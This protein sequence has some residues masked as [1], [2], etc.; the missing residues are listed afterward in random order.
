MAYDP[1]KPHPPAAMAYDASKP[2]PPAAES[3]LAKPHLSAA[4]DSP[5]AQV[6]ATIAEQGGIS[7]DEP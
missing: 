6:R 7:G 4:G 2:H 5:D 1:S 3:D